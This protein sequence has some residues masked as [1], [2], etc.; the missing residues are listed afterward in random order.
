[1]AAACAGIA[2]IKKAD[3]AAA[4]KALVFILFAETRQSGNGSAFLPQLDNPSN[5]P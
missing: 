1:M 5:R 4:V 2:E 3:K